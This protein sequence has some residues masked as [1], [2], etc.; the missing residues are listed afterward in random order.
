MII[1]YTYAKL[2]IKLLILLIILPFWIVYSFARYIVFKQ[3]FKKQLQL[4]GL[5]KETANNLS[6]ELKQF[7]PLKLLSK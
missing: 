5:D 1:I 4:S 3:S 7:L 6:K 2:I